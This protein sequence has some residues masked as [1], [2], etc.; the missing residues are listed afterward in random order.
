MI[1]RFQ[2]AIIN[3]WYLLLPPLLVFRTGMC[4]SCTNKII[5]TTRYF[6]NKSEQVCIESAQT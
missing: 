6:C 4:V 5:F 1:A 2:Q 3:A